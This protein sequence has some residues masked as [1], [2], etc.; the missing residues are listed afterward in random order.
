[1]GIP[2]SVIFFEDRSNTTYDNASY[3]KQI[4]DSVQLNPP[5]LLVTSAYHIPR[6]FL[7]FNNAGV[8]TV[9]FPCNYNSGR[10]GSSFWSLVPKLTVL[11]DWNPYL[12]EA[13]GYFW[14]KLT[15][16]KA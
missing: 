2:D 4:L 16:K 3:A 12:K 1:M 10:G 5:Y 15:M 11:S 9:P 6:A 13:V 14:Y 8:L 7:L